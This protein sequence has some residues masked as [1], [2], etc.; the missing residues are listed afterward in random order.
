MPVTNGFHQPLEAPASLYA[1]E[2]S[3][4]LATRHR[5]ATRGLKTHGCANGSLRLD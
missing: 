5:G 1:D 2:E 3:I 4:L